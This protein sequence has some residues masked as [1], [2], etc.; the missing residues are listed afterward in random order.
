MKYCASCGTPHEPHA[1]FCAGCG[2]SLRPA[3]DV[4]DSGVPATEETTGPATTTSASSSDPEPGP[5]SAVLHEHRD[6]TAPASEPTLAIPADSDSVLATP[7]AASG[8]AS[9]EPPPAR[10]VASGAGQQTWE[11]PQPPQAPTLTERWV[12]HTQSNLETQSL[13]GGGLSVPPRA[14]GDAPVGRPE[15]SRRLLLIAS[16]VMA[17]LIV[18]VAAVG[19]RH[20]TSA[21]SVSRAVGSTAAPTSS[22]STLASK[23]A[24]TTS[25]TKQVPIAPTPDPQVV[26]IAA[27]QANR[28]D[29]LHSIPLTGQWI[30]Q[31]ASKTPGI[32]DPNQI[33]A[34]GGHTFSAADILS[35]FLKARNNP[36]YGSYVGLLLSTDYGT[37][38]LYKGQAL[39]VTF[40]AVP[41]FS[42]ADDVRTWCAQQF[43]T[44]TGTVLDDS[45]T[46]RTLD[47][48]G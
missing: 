16:V 38:Q 44:L 26:A 6:E 30:A 45:C 20:M 1:R 12:P 4:R 28:A 13:G 18:A 29:D 22:P 32:V 47:P 11:Q 36:N 19:I 46:P 43:P 31:L 41:G 33:T 8:A 24:A 10:G 37:P 42:S 5:A 39:W 7:P 14:S 23:P 35:E 48:L 27:L 17:V 9:I 2:T 25:P 15:R 40:A 21:S 34:Q 3:P